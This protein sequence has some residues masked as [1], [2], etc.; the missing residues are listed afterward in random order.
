MRP[1]TLIPIQFKLI[2]VRVN[3]DCNPGYVIH[4]WRWVEL[5]LQSRLGYEECSWRGL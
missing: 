5:G 4:L 2:R 3:A 1:L